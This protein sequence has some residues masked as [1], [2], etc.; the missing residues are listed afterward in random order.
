M[1]ELALVLLMIDLSTVQV[2]YHH[3]TETDLVEENPIRDRHDTALLGFFLG[4]SSIM[5][6]RL[7]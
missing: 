1:T 5:R 7:T 6:Q 2:V 4:A 3:R